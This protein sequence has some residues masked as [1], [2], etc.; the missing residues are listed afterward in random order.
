MNISTFSYY[1]YVLD[2]AVYYVGKKYFTMLI[3]IILNVI[4]YKGNPHGKILYFKFNKS[5]KSQCAFLWFI[6]QF[7]L[8]LKKI[9]Q[10]MNC[11]LFI[12]KLYTGN[13]Y[14]LRVKNIF[15]KK[16]IW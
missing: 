10:N 9:D 11:F 16:I 12:L 15:L 2:Y 4:N 6:K 5:I 14:F 7:S 13:K 1:D 8:C 3:K